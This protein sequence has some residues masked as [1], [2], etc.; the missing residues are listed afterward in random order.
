MGRRHAQAEVFRFQLLRVF[1]IIEQPVDVVAARCF[2]RLDR[3][4]FLK[5]QAVDQ[6]LA[7]KPR[8]I[9]APD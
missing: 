3:A 5:R 9:M 4:L 6:I 8:L 2:K 1:S 7:I